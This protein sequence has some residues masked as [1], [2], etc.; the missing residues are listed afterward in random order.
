MCACYTVNDEIDQHDQWCVDRN[1]NA[2]VATQTFGIN[3]K[4]T[5]HLSCR[6]DVV[7]VF[8]RLLYLEALGKL[9]GRRCE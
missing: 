4:S 9:M 8:T 3:G 5:E 1:V 6:I 2:I 7:Q